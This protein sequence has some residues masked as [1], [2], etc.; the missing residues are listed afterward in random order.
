MSYTPT[1]WVTGDIVT[2]EKLNKL[3]NA[4]ANGVVPEYTS[5]DKDKVLTLGEGSGSE[6]VIIV[7]EQSLT[8]TDDAMPTLNG[9][10]EAYFVVGQECTLTV[11]EDSYAVTVTETDQSDPT[12][13]IEYI[14]DTVDYGI[15]F[16]SNEYRFYVSDNDT[17]ELVPGT[18]TVTLTA[19]VPSVEPKWEGIIPIR[20]LI[21]GDISDGFMVVDI[22]DYPNPG[23]V[24][25]GDLYQKFVPIAIANTCD[26]CFP[27]SSTSVEGGQTYYNIVFGF[28]TVNT[29]TD[30]MTV[31][32]L[33][34]KSTSLDTV[35]DVFSATV[36]AYTLTP[37]V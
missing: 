29:N 33:L 14:G 23:T 15:V 25:L 36:K 17:G 19:T 24:K 1:E 37:A 6:T 30:I 20:Y 35:I 10:E 8:V 7:P 21:G 32:K 3:E 13:M 9:V 34:F 18:Y 31:T 22:S 5:A 4:V 27:I 12:P 11:N 28:K 16:I 2:A 26:V